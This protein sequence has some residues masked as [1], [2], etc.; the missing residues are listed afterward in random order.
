[1]VLCI[2]NM[3]AESAVDALQWLDWF[4]S[5]TYLQ[6]KEE[7]GFVCLGSDANWQASRTH[8]SRVRVILE[9]LSQQNF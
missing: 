8:N 6:R 9:S 1:M 4:V 7:M 5:T 3:D 2:F